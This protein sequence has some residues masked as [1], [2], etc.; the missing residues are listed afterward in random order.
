MG[1]TPKV[2][3]DRSEQIMDAAL[4]VFAQKGFARATIKDI[5]HEAGVT[6]GLIYHYF[7]SKEALLKSIFESRTPLQLIR[8]IPEQMLELPPDKFL[9]T[10]LKNMLAIV[11]SEK[12]LRVLRVYLPE[13]IYNPSSNTIG[14]SAIHEATEFLESYLT[15]KMSSGELRQTDAGLITH[16]LLGCMMDF[17]LRRQVLRDPET[18]RYSHDEIVDCLIDM[19]ML[20][21]APR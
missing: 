18:L 6:S 10:F 3:E 19:A 20:G 2:V 9:R 5:G 21:L 4:R 11:E 1:R 15:A 17:A 14:A 8:T 12:F 13:A 16:L 7:E